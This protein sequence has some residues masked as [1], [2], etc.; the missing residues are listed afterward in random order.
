MIYGT[1]NKE[2]IINS[3]LESLKKDAGIT[4]VQPGSVAKAFA[5]AIGTEI[6]DLYSSLSFTLQQG[7]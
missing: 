3:I 5:D 1:K 4:S 2:E 7:G 6:A